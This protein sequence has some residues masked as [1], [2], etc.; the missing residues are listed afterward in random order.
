VADLFRDTVLLPVAFGATR[1]IL[2][3]A[4]GPVERVVR[5]LAGETFR[6]EKVVSR[7]ID[8]IKELLDADDDR[9]HA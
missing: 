5:Q 7:M 9:G 8:R 4:A 2:R 3:E 1:K 6:R